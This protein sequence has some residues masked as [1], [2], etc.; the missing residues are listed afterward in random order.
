[1][2]KRVFVIGAL[3]LLVVILIAGYFSLDARVTGKVLFH[4][5]LS[6]SEESL[7]NGIELDSRNRFKWPSTLE[8][9]SIEDAFGDI[10]NDIRF[11]RARVGGTSK[12]WFNPNKYGQRRN[13]RFNSRGRLIKNLNPGDNY[14]LRM[15]KRGVIWS[16]T[17]GS[18]PAKLV[19]PNGDI[20]KLYRNE[21]ISIVNGVITRNGKYCSDDGRACTISGGYDPDAVGGAGGGGCTPVCPNGC[22]DG[23]CVGSNDTCTDS[24]GGNGFYEKGY[25]TVGGINYK[26]YCVTSPNNASTTVLEEANCDYTDYYNNYDCSWEGKICQDGACVNGTAN[27][28]ANQ[29][30][31]CR[32]INAYSGDREQIYIQ[33]RGDDKMDITFTEYRGYNR[34]FNFAKSVN[35][36]IKLVR[37]D[38]NRS[39]II[40]E[41]EVI[42]DEDY[43][44]VGNEDEGY[45]LRL[46]S[47]KNQSSGYFN[48]VCRFTDVFSGHVYEV[49]WTGE[50]VGTV[51]IGGK[52]YGVKM[53]GS[54]ISASE[55]YEVRLDY[56]DSRWS[57]VIIYP[58]IQTSKGAKI[59]FYE[60][61]DKYNNEGALLD[62]SDYGNGSDI[63][64]IMIPDGDGYKE[65]SVSNQGMGVWSIGGKSINTTYANSKRIDFK[66]GVLRFNI[67]ASG[68]MDKVNLILIRD[69]GDVWSDT[70]AKVIVFEEKDDNGDYNALI[71]NLEEGSTAEDGIGV[72]KVYRTWSGDDADYEFIDSSNN[73]LQKECDLWGTLAVVDSG[74]SDQLSAVISYPNTQ[75]F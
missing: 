28:T 15:N 18:K 23:R 2:K 52:T 1:M 9:T 31:D 50:G 24:D 62:L 45:L 3:V 41:G 48:D 14:Y 37:D 54:S 65:L 71:V 11:I 13:D 22:E 47:V 34:T 42:Y 39:I 70:H 26:D 17:P 6:L 16:Y 75:V 32:S 4:R 27:Q 59:M 60:P 57:D 25:I 73:R 21:E 69:D 68:I 8:E 61:F 5:S 56:P 10:I 49:T 35:N 64:G 53:S 36:K 12:Y 7:R 43:V 33:P 38:D 29:T 55:D 67:I 19:L 40:L 66:V 46:S 74:N 30:V 44:V 63:S 51:N 72:E 58:T 20:W